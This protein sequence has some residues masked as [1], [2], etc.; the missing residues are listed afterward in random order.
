MIHQTRPWLGAVPWQTVIDTNQ[1]LYKSIKEEEPAEA[2]SHPMTQRNY[3]QAQAFWERARQE[4]TT[5]TEALEQCSQCHD[6]A[7]FTF[8]NSKTFGEVAVIM[9]DELLSGFSS[10]EAQ[11]LKNT[12]QHFVTNDIGKKE[13][14]KVLRHLGARAGESR[15]PANTPAAVP[16]VRPQPQA[17]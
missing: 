14:R 16:A 10:I 2:A 17:F 7:P 3:E 5:L 1:K 6:L 4:T 13:L 8:N 12:L 11:I 15:A 9:V